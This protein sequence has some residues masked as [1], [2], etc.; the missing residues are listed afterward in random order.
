VYTHTPPDLGLIRT[1][2][3]HHN[4]KKYRIPANCVETRT[5][6][7]FQSGV[8]RKHC[9]TSNAGGSQTPI[10]ALLP[11]FSKAKRNYNRG[12]AFGQRANALEMR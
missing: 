11:G 2:G 3:C 12:G 9:S 6:C 10:G 7:F 1:F 8:A 5:C 4:S